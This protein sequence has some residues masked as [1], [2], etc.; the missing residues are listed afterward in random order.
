M[1][2]SK[3]NLI[4]IYASKKGY[5][6]IG[7]K[8]YSHRDKE[9][10][11]LI[12][13]DG[14]PTISVSI[15]N[16]KRYPVKIHRLVA[17]QKFGDAL[18]KKGIQVRHLN[19]NKLDFSFENIEI[20]TAKQNCLDKPKEQRLQASKKANSLMKRSIPFDL[21]CQI[22]EELKKEYE[23]GDYARIARKY[24]INSETVRGIKRGRYSTPY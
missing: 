8:V 5:K 20:G 21:A 19:G 23:Y 6:V 17:Y 15:S 9:L 4:L 7:N 12:L 10:K 2:L 13:P 22:R 18:F 24:N 16:E 1:I 14:Y 11:L 3:S